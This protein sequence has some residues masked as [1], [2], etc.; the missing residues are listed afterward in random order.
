MTLDRFHWRRVRVQTAIFFAGIVASVL[1]AG[2]F[3]ASGLMLSSSGFGRAVAWDPSESGFGV[4]IGALCALGWLCTVLLGARMARF[5]VHTDGVRAYGWTLVILN[6]VIAVVLCF[7]AIVVLPTQ[8][9]Y[10][11]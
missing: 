1:A 2:M 10:L 11:P 9:G 4:A 8:Y 5:D 6:I 3:N 7:F